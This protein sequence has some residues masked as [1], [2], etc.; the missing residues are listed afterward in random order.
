MPP[1]AAVT[2]ERSQAVTDE[3]PSPNGIPGGLEDEVAGLGLTLVRATAA[4]RR[5]L[6]G[7]RLDESDKDALDQVRRIFLAAA[8]TLEGAMT[9][10]SVSPSPTS[11]NAMEITLETAL[12]RPDASTDDQKLIAFLQDQSRRVDRLLKNDDA[13]NVK[14]TLTLLESLLA[15]LDEHAGSHGDEVLF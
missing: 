11:Y 13:D 5:L 6:K 9:G 7:E 10:R 15:H 4:A 12:E 1:G 2:S 14:D 8:E 3:R